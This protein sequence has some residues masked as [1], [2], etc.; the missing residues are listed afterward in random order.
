M[1]KQS[2]MLTLQVIYDGLRYILGGGFRLEDAHLPRPHHTV[3]ADF[4][5][6][7]VASNADPATDAYII[8]QLREL[9]IVD[10]RVDLSFDDI[11]S[12]Q[13]RFCE[14]LLEAGFAVTL[15]LIPPFES[16]K[17]MHLA[18]EQAS[19]K[20]FIETVITRYGKRV[21]Q[22]EIGNTI[23]RKRWAGYNWPAFY[24]AWEIAYKTIKAKHITLLGAN[25]Q[26][27][28]PGYNVS[29]LKTLNTKNQLP[30]VQTNNLFVERISEPERY[31]HRVLKYQWAKIFKYNLV[32]KARLL[33]KI[34]EDFGVART[35][36]TG[37]FWAIYRIERR[38]LHGAQKQADYLTRYFTLLAASGQFKQVFWGTL[39]CHREGLIDDGLQD[40]DYP[41][42]ER[43]AHY[44]H[45]DGDCQQYKPHPSFYAMQTVV[46][47]LVGAQ[48]IGY[49]ASSAGLEIHQFLQH[50]KQVHVAW[51]LNGTAIPLQDVYSQDSLMAAHYLGRDGTDFV[52]ESPDLLS[53]E[54]L[55]LSWPKAFEVQTV[56]KPRLK[57]PLN[58]DAH[59]PD[60]V[61]F[62]CH[63]ANWRG[64]V[65][66]SN[67]AAFN[68][69]MTAL[70]PDALLAPQ[71]A[72]SLRH[73][74]NVI[75]AMPHPN[76]ATRQIT[77]KKPVNMYW[78]KRVLDRNR[79]S[80]AR[81]SWNGAMQLMRRGI[82]TARPIAF[83]EREDDN[84]LKQNFYI[85]DFVQAD[86]HIGQVFSA[87]AAGETT[88]MQVSQEQVYAQLARFIVR[89]HDRGCYFRDLSGGNI[90][91]NIQDQTLQF[92]L[93]DTARARFND[94]GV[95]MHQRLSDLT[96]ACNKLN[97]HGRERFLGHYL[98]LIGRQLT[99]YYKLPFYLYDAKVW[100]KRRVG[101][102]GIKKLMRKIKGTA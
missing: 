90:L 72:Q 86:C 59:L 3:P 11:I 80:K 10:V 79:P 87:F 85:C 61:Y 53:E 28:E 5:G 83:F 67:Q 91:V 101:R 24:I 2:S 8:Q 84:S 89:M 31:D 46:Q 55:Y 49:L 29:L 16:A 50:G 63:Q 54:P 44:R 45:A 69:L 76:D 1:T 12:F 97:W 92:H 21:K 26:D 60:S 43:V 58:I 56:S 18:S 36:S 73:A 15:R 77:I 100:L 34:G 57:M 47:Q 37:A 52:H 7:G 14:A 102:K 25:I 81:R 38:L 32:K 27:F 42:L 64:V 51:T 75:W 70:N 95:P 94:V 65:L 13:G 71:K 9:G 62:T 99:W 40:A 19:W 68:E 96:R 74:R 35:I 6:V 48:Y 78:H 98:G 4:V 66:A 17:N 23:N 33:C 39:V 20:A 93:I 30:D 88:Y 82:A 41:T 22:I